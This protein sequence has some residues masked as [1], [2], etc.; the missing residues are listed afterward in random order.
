MELTTRNKAA[1]LMVGCSFLLMTLDLIRDGWRSL[2]WIA[3]LF[4]ALGYFA[5]AEGYNVQ[6]ERSKWHSP[7]FLAGL[8]AM[9]LGLGLMAYFSVSR[10]LL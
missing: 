9:L 10:Y 7:Q 8:A 1:L 6:S 2:G 4:F 5:M 3:W